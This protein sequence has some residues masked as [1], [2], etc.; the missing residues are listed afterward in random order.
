MRILL[1]VHQ[2][3]PKHS[4]GTEVLTRDTGLEMLAR[5]HEVH[6]LTVDPSAPRTSTEVTY[7]DYDYKGLKVHA[8][9]LP[10]RRSMSYLVE[11]EYDNDLV[12]AHVR[13]YADLVRPDAVHMFHLMR[14]SGSVI[15]VF[16]DLGVPVVFTPT[17]FWA[18]CVRV[19]LMKPSGELSAGPDDISSNCLECRGVERYLP[20]EE[21]PDTPDKQVM[22]RRIAERS[23]ARSE[24]EHPSMALVRAMLG[25]TRSLRESIN[26]VNAILAPTELMYRTLVANGI[27]PR[28][29]TVSP[30]GI[31]LSDFQIIS[32]RRS[33]PE[34]LR[35]GYIGAV[36]PQKGLHILLRAFK[37]LP[38]EA[39]VSLRICGDLS[40]W[41]DY[42]QRVY[43]EAASD[44][45]INFAGP[46]PNEKMA[47]EL[48][49]ID[50]LVVPSM[51]YENA[52]LVIYSALA[53]G[54]PVVGSNQDGIAEIIDGKNGLLFRSGDPGDL[55]RQLKRLIT[56]P[57][58]LARLEGNGSNVRT[59]EDSVAEMLAL[60]KCLQRGYR[61]QEGVED[62]N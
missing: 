51:W 20:P 13:W 16:R 3:L 1:T 9:R 24:N 41:P 46:F 49:K 40:A 31:D 53:A 4:S 54:I 58:L 19:T 6:V 50:V 29:I 14:L 15:Q 44:S 37:R 56:E 32:R 34:K 33:D 36:N 10:R 18:I 61:R 45:Q 26:T 35:L 59:V 62:S 28:L 27:D 60:Y 2:F 12:A 43:A 8:L 38:R 17:D 11:D 47:G 57:D 25:R 23:L 55:A 42:S 5:G 7:E 30:Y 22:Y 52:P 39:D 48:E 21:L